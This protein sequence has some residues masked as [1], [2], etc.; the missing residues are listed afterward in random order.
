MPSVEITTPLK[1]NSQR[2]REVKLANNFVYASEM[3]IGLELR[4]PVAFGPLFFQF[5]ILRLNF[6]FL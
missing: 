5:I 6:F 2:T 4:T 3:H 1:E